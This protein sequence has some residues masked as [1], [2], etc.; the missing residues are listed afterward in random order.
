MKN[1]NYAQYN[2]RKCRGRK[3]VIKNRLMGVIIA[4]KLRR[5]IFRRLEAETKMEVFFLTMNIQKHEQIID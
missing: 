5:Y 1:K 2:T 3:K 4:E